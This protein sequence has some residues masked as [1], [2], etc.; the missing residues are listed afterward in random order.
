VELHF[1]TEILKILLRDHMTKKDILWATND[2]EN[3]LAEEEIKVE[4]L[5]FIC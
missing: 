2:Y 5:D 4:Q 3:I 1:G